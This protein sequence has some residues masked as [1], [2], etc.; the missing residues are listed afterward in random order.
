M[1]PTPGH[2][3]GQAGLSGCLQRGQLD[4]GKGSW[5]VAQ[6]T[7]GRPISGQTAPRDTPACCTPG[8]P[9]TASGRVSG[10]LYL[11]GMSLCRPL[12]VAGATRPRNPRP[13]ARQAGQPSLVGWW[14]R[15]P[16]QTTALGSDSVPVA[17]SRR[18]QETQHHLAQSHSW[19]CQFRTQS[20]GCKQDQKILLR[21]G[22]NASALFAS[23]SREHHAAA[24]RHWEGGWASEEAGLWPPT[25]REMAWTKVGAQ[26][27]RTGDGQG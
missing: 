5:P 23:K 24:L 22:R 13:A 18:G 2:D 3:Q 11:D 4:L 14:H 1:V 25:S 15:L 16:T 8:G 6:G 10:R 19:S 21:S 26:R 27:W 17:P 20:T 7:Q 12:Q 9:V